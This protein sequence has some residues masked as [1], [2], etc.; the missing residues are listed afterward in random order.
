[1]IKIKKATTKDQ[2]ILLIFTHLLHM[3]ESK[4]EKTDKL[5]KKA[6]KDDIDTIIYGLKDKKVF[7][8]LAYDNKM[9]IGY[10]KM[11]IKKIN[12][13][14]MGHLGATFILEKFRGLGAGKKLY[15]AMV[16]TL[17]QKKINKFS[18]EVYKTN[19]LSINV[20]K[21]LGFKVIGEGSNKKLYRMEKTL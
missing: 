16:K 1:M 4:I 17:K 19:K 5:D 12:D 8:Y 18:L 21:K 7:F 2:D 6:I 13:E 14:I 11:K 3:Y 20:H 10:C 9:P 15:L